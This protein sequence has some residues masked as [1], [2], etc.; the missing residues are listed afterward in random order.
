VGTELTLGRLGERITREIELKNEG[1][2]SASF[3]FKPPS[4]DKSICALT[5][6]LLGKYADL[7]GKPTI[8]PFPPLGTIEPGQK[9]TL[10]IS[11]MVDE[12]WS[13]RLTLGE[14]DLNG[15]L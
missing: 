12:S 15:E 7:S 8:W 3:S 2:V 14:D 6:K 13:R 5:L 10:K 11:M 4:A 1:R 9:T